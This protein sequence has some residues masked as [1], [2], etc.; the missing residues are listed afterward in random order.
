MPGKIYI[1]YKFTKKYIKYPIG[2]KLLFECIHIQWLLK[3][4]RIN[5]VNKFESQGLNSVKILVRKVR[6]YHVLLYDTSTSFG[7]SYFVF[8][9]YLVFNFQKNCFGAKAFTVD[10]F[11]KCASLCHSSFCLRL[12][13]IESVTIRCELNEPHKNETVWDF[14][15][16]V[17]HKHSKAFNSQVLLWIVMKNIF[18]SAIQ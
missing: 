9:L 10:M 18:T 6:K 2:L 1:K 4:K 15:A 7:L 8:L 11:Y 17:A 3:Y 13:L 14:F 12:F 5:H 16:S